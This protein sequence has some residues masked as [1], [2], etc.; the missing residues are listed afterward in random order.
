MEARE[1][2]TSRKNQLITKVAKLSDKKHR[3]A[4]GL[5]RIDGVKL[6]LE[7]VQSGIKLE[8]TF[9]AVS[10]REHILELLASQLENIGGTIHF[11][12]D[13]VFDKLTDEA[14]PQGIVGVAKKYHTVP[15][16]I[17]CSGD[18]RAIYLS[19]VRD[20]GNLG[21]IIRTAYAFGVD[22]VFVSSDCADIYSPK[23]LRAAMGNIFR[24][25]I[26]I[27]SDEIAFANEIQ[28]AGCKIYAAALNREARRL[29]DFELPNRV[30]VAVGNEGHGLS[31]EFISACSGAVFIPIM[32]GC[33]SLN[34]ASASSVLLW[35]MQRE[36]GIC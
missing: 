10:K 16:S 30:C 2:I 20:P 3:D 14:A 36:K 19:S 35:E 12:S 6:F 5:F 31:E 9:I 33:E 28:S 29:G 22:R 34:V 25:P 7:A 23:T 4:E 24:Q 27:V 15:L 11:V 21:T 32:S 8:H 17:P 13:D 18:F 1:I 26:S